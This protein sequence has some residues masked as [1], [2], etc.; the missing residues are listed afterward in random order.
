[1]TTPVSSPLTIAFVEAHPRDAARIVERLD[2]AEAGSFADTLPAQVCAALLAALTPDAASRCIIAM[3][4][5]AAIAGMQ[6]IDAATLAPILRRVPSATRD[7]LIAGMPSRARRALRTVMAYPET[8]VGSAID[9]LS[10]T[11]PDDID[12]AEAVRLA[13]DGRD[14][15]KVLVGVLD[16]ENRLVGMVDI[17]DLLTTDPSQSIRAITGKAPG[18]LSTQA[19]L[20]GAMEHHAWRHASVLPVED[21]NRI[22]VGVLDRNAAFR[23]VERITTGEATDAPETFLALA[24]L[25]WGTFS[26]IFVGTTGGTGD[27][28]W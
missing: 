17:R 19:N 16:T 4:A 28:R 6:S 26:G 7:P 9:P 5:T 20:A 11:F 10:L 23:A 2:V 24:D 25:F 3:T 13:K 18:V 1:M 14:R 21:P 12:V 15:L 22:F 27:E 8:L